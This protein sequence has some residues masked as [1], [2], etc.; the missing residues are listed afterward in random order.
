MIDLND[1]TD[2]QLLAALG[3]VSSEGPADCTEILRKLAPGE[4]LTRWQLL[5]LP[6]HIGARLRTLYLAGRVSRH[7][8]AYGF[9]YDLT[10]KGAQL[11]KGGDA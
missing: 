1:V 4:K 9:R 11:A 8:T 2:Q 6:S 3:K 10:A 5:S 7:R